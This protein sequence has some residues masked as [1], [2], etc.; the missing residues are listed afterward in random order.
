MIRRNVNAPLDPATDAALLLRRIGFA[1]LT[2]ALPMASLVSR[3]A[4]VVL[5]PIG[6]ALLVIS[7]L[8]E[9]RSWFSQKLKE[10]LLTR[11]GMILLGVVAWSALSLTWSPDASAAAEKAGN[12]MLAI[13]LGF[14]GAAALPDRMR[15]SNLNLIAI[16]T[17]LAG[18]FALVLFM[19]GWLRESDA[20]VATGSV[21]RGVSVVLITSWPA[22]AWLV[23]RNRGLSALALALVV[24]L[25]ALTR[26]ETGEAVAM[27]CGAVAFG[28][29]YANRDAA[30]PVIA[31]IVAGL[32]LFA[33]LLPFLL[34]PLVSMLPSDTSALHQA[35]GI[36]A[37]LV[38]TEPI[39]F[40]TGHGL[41]TV[42]SSRLNGLLPQATPTTLLFEAW[43]ELGIVGAAAASI[44]LYFAIK[45]TVYMPGALAAGVAA[46]YT[47]GFALTALGFATL[48]PWWLMTLVAVAMLFTAVARGQHKTDRP[49][50]PLSPKSATTPSH[51]RPKA[52]GPTPAGK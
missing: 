8:I 9:E 52:G 22:L 3:R 35:L 1:T 36:W 39:R 31:A 21:E 41:D 17:A 6:V 49:L 24:G 44:C 27:I 11:P 14:C 46:A 4:A 50:A 30:A 28:A 47:T 32:M 29:V 7:S 34:L 51:T 37:D 42:L 18:L 38:G 23:S 12:L 10:S 2:L 15:A 13:A 19:T 16:G 45:A 25:L 5:T 20:A 33:P 48:Q 43:Y 40:I 26:F